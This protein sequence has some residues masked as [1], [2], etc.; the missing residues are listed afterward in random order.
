VEKT[1]KAEEIYQRLQQS[2]GEPQWEPGRDPVDE[3]ILTI[4]S[5]NTNDTNSGRAFAQLKNNFDHDWE[6]IRCAPLDCIKQAIRPAGM[7]HQ[8]APH[9][10][11]TLEKLYQERGSYNLDHLASMPV[12]DALAYLMTFPGVGHKTASIVLLFCFN[13]GSFPVDTHVQ[14]ITQ[15]LG[16]SSPNANTLQIKTL[17]ESLLPPD[18]Y[19]ALHLNLITHGRQTCL[20]RTPKCAICLLQALCAYYRQQQS[21]LFTVLA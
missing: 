12:A 14:R 21:A 18:R 15:R 6:K 4:L 11:A 20:A 9:I 7:Y 5:A 1:Q 13:R 3:L 16:I 2:Y 8:K 19:Y 10:V 17:W